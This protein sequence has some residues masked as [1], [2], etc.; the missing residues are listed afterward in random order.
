MGRHAVDTNMLFIDTLP[1]PA[2]DL[3]GE[4]G[5]G[6]DY[7]LHAFNP[8]RILD[9]GRGDRYRA[10]MRCARGEIC[11]RARRLRT[12]D[13]AEPGDPAS[14]GALRGRSSRRRG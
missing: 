5:K 3:I 6:F 14:A 2:D 8:E 9:R 13:R 7:L 4:E 12:T 1:V 10:Q 11:A